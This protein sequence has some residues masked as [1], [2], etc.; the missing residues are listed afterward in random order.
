MAKINT[1]IDLDLTNVPEDQK[2]LVKEE[3]KEFL[4]DRTLDYISQGKSPVQNEG[5][6]KRLNKEYAA[7][8]KGGDRTPNME[9]SGSMLDAY[10][11]G[12]R[13]NKSDSL[14]FSASGDE[15]S[16]MEGHNHHKG[17][18]KLPRRRF[19]PTKEQG[20]KKEIMDEVNSLIDEY[21]VDPEE[22]AQSPTEVIRERRV[23][24]QGPGVGV[25][26]DVDNFISRS[27]TLDDLDMDNDLITREIN[28]M[29]RG[30]G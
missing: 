24:E 9:L 27:F 4:I 15:G 30:R 25:D 22:T 29:R 17:P 21:R 6:W 10:E 12:W 7:L 2:D 26:G 5:R 18:S 23:T 1:R 3:V 16:K 20:Y 19:I 8:E 11:S 28:R 14:S 13:V